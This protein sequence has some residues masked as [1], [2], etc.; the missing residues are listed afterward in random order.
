MHLVHEEV[1][2]NGCTLEDFGT[3]LI[4][5]VPLGVRIGA[6][7]NVVLN[8]SFDLE[9][10]VRTSIVRSP[11]QVGEN[12]PI[13]HPP[14]FFLARLP[15]TSTSLA[16][17]HRLPL[18]YVLK[19]SLAR[20]VGIDRGPHESCGRVFVA[21]MRLLRVVSPGVKSTG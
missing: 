1:G 4:V 13:P 17:C 9:R 11:L 5:H 20:H 3:W 6:H 14:F 21:W 18:Y 10:R 12:S 8:L 19:R 2:F 7:S 15:T 16:L